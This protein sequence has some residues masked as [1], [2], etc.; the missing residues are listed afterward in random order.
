MSPREAPIIRSKYL[1]QHT[2]NDIK[3]NKYFLVASVFVA[4]IN[5]LQ[6]L[7]LAVKEYRIY[8]HPNKKTT[9]KLR[10]P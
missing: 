1:H 2:T 5:F 10:G 9:N 7:C 3:P 6:T 8:I 4:G